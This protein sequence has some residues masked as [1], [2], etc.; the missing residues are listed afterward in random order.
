[1]EGLVPS[2]DVGQVALALINLG[3]LALLAWLRIETSRIKSEVDE[4]KQNHGS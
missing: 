3:Q 1:M 2:V 4:V